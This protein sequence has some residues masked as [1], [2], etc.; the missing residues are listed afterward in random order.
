MSCKAFTAFCNKLS[1]LFAWLCVIN[2]MDSTVYELK[3]FVLSPVSFFLVTL[4]FR[5]LKFSFIDT[6]TVKVQRTWSCIFQTAVKSMLSRET[7]KANHAYTYH[8]LASSC[9]SFRVSSKILASL[10]RFCNKPSTSFVYYDIE[11]M[12][13]FNDIQKYQLSNKS[14]LIERDNTLIAYLH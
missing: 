13:S 2:L 14:M 4:K 10:N 6:H 11:T 9:V 5:H 1:D 3:Y 8:W 7:K 12:Y